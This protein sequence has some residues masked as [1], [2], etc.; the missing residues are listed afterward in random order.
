[1]TSLNV[2]KRDGKIQIFDRT[3]ISTSLINAGTDVEQAENI[4]VQIEN[5]SKE[6]A[7]G[8]IILTKDIRIKLLELLKPINPEA[9]LAYEKYKKNA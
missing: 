1:M 8:G 3:K 6:N 5:W 4:T 2:Q 7:K 9:A